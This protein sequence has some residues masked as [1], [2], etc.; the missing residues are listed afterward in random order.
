MPNWIQKTG[1]GTFT[2]LFCGGI[3]MQNIQG[4]VCPNESCEKHHEIHTETKELS[5]VNNLETNVSYSGEASG[6]SMYMTHS[7][8]ENYKR[9]G[10]E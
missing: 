4:F 3:V 9:G 10:G 8:L 2:C 1:F 6:V 5:N 7:L